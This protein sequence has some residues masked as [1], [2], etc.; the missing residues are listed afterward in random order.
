[1]QLF[2]GSKY[3]GIAAAY[4]QRDGTAGLRQSRGY[5]RTIEPKALILLLPPVPL[6]VAGD[7]Q[8]QQQILVIQLLHLVHDLPVQLGVQPFR[9]KELHRCDLK[10][11]TDV[12]KLRHRWQGLPGGNALDIVAV[13]PQRQAHLI[14]GDIFLQAKL[15]YSLPNIC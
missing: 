9:I 14:F 7:R 15:R 4:I 5:P 13:H 1:M 10:I 8:Q 12:Q 6:E 11:L 3:S 2:R